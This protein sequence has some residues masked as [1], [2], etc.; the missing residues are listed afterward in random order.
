[1]NR[2]LRMEFILKQQTPTYWLTGIFLLFL[3]LPS[4]SQNRT[5][6]IYGK[7]TTSSNQYEGVIRWGKE[8]AIWLDYFNA[9]KK[10]HNTYR[11]YEQKS[12]GSQVS[13]LELDWDIASIWEDRNT[14]HQFNCQF[15]DIK[16]IKV[17]ARKS[18]RLQFKNG[19]EIDVMGEEFNDMGEGI[20]IQ[21]K[22]LGTLLIDWSRI[23]KIEFATAPKNV[24]AVKPLFGT[25]ETNRREKFTGYVIWDRDERVIS[26]KLDGQTKDGGVSMP[27]AEIKSIERK[28]SGCLT[29]LKSDR[30]FMVTGS[31]DVNE[32]NRGLVVLIPGKGQVDIPWSSFKKVVFSDKEET[33][34]AYDQFPTPKPLTGKVY[35][36][37][38]K[39]YSGT[40]VY[41]F[42]ETLDLETLEGT[43]NGIRYT[44]PFRNI[45]SIRPK[46]EAYSQVELRNG[47][48]LLL[49]GSNDVCTG[50]GGVLIFQKG[51][52]EPIH[53]TRRKIDQIL[54]EP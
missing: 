32:S 23:D 18:A 7:I 16:S 8:E 3:G 45:K 43:D 40:L 15:G 44:I 34:P 9:S 28:G 11:E 6:L 20:E 41:D 42:D 49:G 47:E 5:G 25:V 33:G 36:F 24:P 2:F 48:S 22:E 21:D 35:L 51:K 50:N 38:D 46:N 26:D 10:D 30:E 29:I 12:D 37:E 39:E 31:N 52:K 19:W 4:F 53:V 27:F 13:W 1:M 14:T 54:F 17:L